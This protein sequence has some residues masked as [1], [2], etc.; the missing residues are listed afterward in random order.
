MQGAAQAVPALSPAN[1][2]EDPNNR[3]APAKGA[4]VATILN[5]FLWVGLFGLGSIL[6]LPR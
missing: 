6:T 3:L 5:V 2:I 4:I 1:E